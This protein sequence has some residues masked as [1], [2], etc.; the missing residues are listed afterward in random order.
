[1]LESLVFQTPVAQNAAAQAILGKLAR[2]KLSFILN[3]IL[4]DAIRSEGV[5]LAA[6]GFPINRTCLKLMVGRTPGPRPG[7]LA[8]LWT[9]KLYELDRR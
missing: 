3:T 5:A 9:M 2:K 4:P 1:M 8:G 7:A 6:S